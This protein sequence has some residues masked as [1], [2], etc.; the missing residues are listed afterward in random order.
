MFPK[1]KVPQ[2]QMFHILK[3]D[4][5]FIK[6]N[7]FRHFNKTNISLTFRGA[8]VGPLHKYQQKMA[9]IP[10]HQKTPPLAALMP[11]KKNMNKVFYTYA[12]ALYVC[13]SSGNKMPNK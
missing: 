6:E 12:A 13:P 10:P 3:A 2:V 8:I 4:K 7:H 5:L 1:M 9:A 11:A